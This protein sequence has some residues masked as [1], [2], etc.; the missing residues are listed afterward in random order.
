MEVDLNPT[1]QTANKPMIDFGS[2]AGYDSDGGLNWFPS[3]AN[4]GFEK[5]NMLKNLR[6]RTQ[7]SPNSA[8]NSR[9]SSIA[10]NE[11]EHF[12]KLYLDHNE[13]IVEEESYMLD[14]SNMINELQKIEEDKKYDDQYVKVDFY[15]ILEFYYF[16][17]ISKFAITESRSSQFRSQNGRPNKSAYQEKRK[18]RSRQDL[19]GPAIKFNIFDDELKKKRNRITSAEQE[20]EDK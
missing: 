7:S 11:N 12:K 18:K 19:V 9:S 17:L 3:S 13:T 14:T 10:G 6:G 15:P 1:Y 5:L 4:E 16:P 20:E 8:C 2:E